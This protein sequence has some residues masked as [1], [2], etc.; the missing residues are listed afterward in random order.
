PANES[1]Q[2]LNFV[3]SGDTNPGLFS[4]G[5]SLAVDGTLTFTAVANANGS[6]QIQVVLHDDGG[7]LRGGVDN[8]NAATLDIT[9]RAVNDPPSFTAGSDPTVLEDAGAQSIAWATN[10][11][12]GPP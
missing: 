6:A 2:A 12:A 8:S 10:I 9:V 3:L 7:T 1:S 4:A 5:P 11:S